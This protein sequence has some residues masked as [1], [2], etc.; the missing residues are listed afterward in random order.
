MFKEKITTKNFE[1]LRGEGHNLA[2][3]LFIAIQQKDRNKVKDILRNI[4]KKIHEILGQNIQANLEF[5]INK[6]GTGTYRLL[7]LSGSSGKRGILDISYS[8]N[9]ELRFYNME[10]IK[11]S[12]NNLSFKDA[13]V[14]LFDLEGDENDYT[15]ELGTIKD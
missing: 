2:K 11:M 8:G 10:N 9:V 7:C 12:P 4:G 15:L 3:L 5:D 14:I 13:V 1:K 6:K